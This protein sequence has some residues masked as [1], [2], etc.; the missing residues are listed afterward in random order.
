M[1]QAD[2][3]GR[4][5]VEVRKRHPQIPWDQV[6]GFRNVA[7][8]AYES[9]H[10]KQVGVVINKD[11]PMLRDALSRSWERGMRRLPM[12]DMVLTSRTSTLDVRVAIG[13]HRPSTLE[14]KKWSVDT[15]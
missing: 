3:A 5:S 12:K 7:T 15:H 9:L 6:R 10:L 13:P 2:A 4:L 8:H 11:L 14:A 1:T